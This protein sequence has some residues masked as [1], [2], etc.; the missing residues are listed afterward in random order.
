MHYLPG[1]GGIEGKATLSLS[2]SLS[3]SL[4]IDSAWNECC[5]WVMDMLR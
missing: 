5:R 3:L 4:Y 2:L 1:K